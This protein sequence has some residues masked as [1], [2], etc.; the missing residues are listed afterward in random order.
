MILFYIG[1]V[2]VLL[3]GLII[4]RA[5]LDLIQ[6]RSTSAVPISDLE[7]ASVVVPVRNEERYIGRCLEGLLAQDCGADG[8]EIVVIDD[9][10]EDRTAEIVQQYSHRGVRYARLEEEKHGKK[11]ALSKGIALATHSIII[12]TDAD[13]THPTTWL[14]TLLHY[15]NTTQA[16]LIAAPVRIRTERNFLE[17]FQSLDFLSLQAITAAAV[18]AKRFNLCNG[19]NLLYTRSAFRYVNGFQGIDHVASGDDV[20]L[21]EKIAR[22]YPG[23]VGYCYQQ[24]VIVDTEPVSSWKEF[25]QQRIRWAGK[26]TVF[27]SGWIKSVL[28]VVYVLN[29]ILFSMMIASIAQ[30][31]LIFFTVLLLAAKAAVEYSFM[32]RAAHFFGKKE[33]MKWFLP[34]QP[35]YVLYIVG[36]ATMGFFKSYEWK[37]RKV[38]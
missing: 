10:S 30:P 14:S 7:K 26:S 12:T 9:G 31:R 22:A 37:G 28:L 1:C 27:Q 16:E 38:R 34:V 3:Y 21:M 4:A 18:S 32:S 17:R 11:A 8:Y 2:F 29:L 35:V 24:A 23:K 20:L 5:E 25:F 19:A 15:R 36:S 6:I 13:C 33:L